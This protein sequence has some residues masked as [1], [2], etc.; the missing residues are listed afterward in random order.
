MSTDTRPEYPESWAVGDTVAVRDGKVAERAT[1]TVVGRR[2]VTVQTESNRSYRFHLSSGRYTD[3]YVGYTPV[4]LTREQAGYDLRV[5][6][7]WT[8]LQD[9][10]MRPDGLLSNGPFLLYLAEAVDRWN[11]EHPL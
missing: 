6:A 3:P 11:T 1:V 2:Y 4:L 8:K 10:G 9:A 5:R 7:A